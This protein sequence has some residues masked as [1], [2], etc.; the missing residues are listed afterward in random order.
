MIK[1]YALANI[2]TWFLYY[3]AVKTGLY[4]DMS[5]GGF[6]NRY[7]LFFLPLWIVYLF[8]SGHEIYKILSGYKAGKFKNQLFYKFIKK[9]IYKL[10]DFYP[11]VAICFLICFCFS[12]WTT[13]IEPNWN[14]G[15]LRGTVSAWY[16][17]GGQDKNTIVYYAA[18]PG[19]VYYTGMDS[20]HEPENNHI[21]Y[22]NWD[23]SGIDYQAYL[24]D[25]Y[26]DNINTWPDEID[27]IIAHRAND[28]DDM[29]SAF[30]AAGYDSR[31][32]YN[33]DFYDE[34]GGRLIRFTSGG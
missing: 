8:A 28:I 25:L 15:D 31:D 5:Y 19:F 7:N 17:N 4:A 21:I 14:K 1:I 34:E 16:E 18:V 26:G 12:E 27:F 33:H 3:F 9:I 22:M 20:R 30:Q 29:I 13:R 11:G 24:A 2:F 32:L 23:D 6:G 10:R